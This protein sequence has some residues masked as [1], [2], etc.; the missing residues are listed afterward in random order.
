PA[1]QDQI[2]GRIDVRF[3]QAASSLGPVKAEQIKAFAVTDNTRLP[4]APEIA[5]VDEAGLAGFHIA[6][7]HGLW[8]P[9]G[10]PKEVTT[11]LNLAVVDALNDPAVRKR[12]TDMGQEIP[13][14]AQ[15]TPQALAAHQKAEID[16]WWPIINAE[17]IKLE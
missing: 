7:W 3:D 9:K 5:T 11:K 2:A 10:T 4:S 6:T 14:A 15:L 17:N 1:L 12:L 8:A 16:K 13:T